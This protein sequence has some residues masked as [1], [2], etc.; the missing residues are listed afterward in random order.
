M[1]VNEPRD[2]SANTP[3]G[4]TKTVLGKTLQK[5]TKQE[6]NQHSRTDD[7]V[8]DAELRALTSPPGY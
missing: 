4:K 6:L 2:V 3:R 1:N 5:R 7:V 8:T